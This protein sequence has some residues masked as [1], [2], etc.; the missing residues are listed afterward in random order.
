MADDRTTALFFELFSG[1]PRQGP[2]D[3]DSTLRALALVPGVGPRTRVLDVGCGTGLHTRVLAQALGLAGRLEARVGDMRQLDFPPGS[4][5]L[6]W[7]EGAIYV[8]GFEAGLREWRTLLAP[9]GHVAVTEVCWMRPDPPPEC[10]AFWAQEYPAIRDVADRL[11]T[12]EACGYETVGHFT[13]PPSSWWNDYYL[14][15]EA[16]LSAFREIHHGEADAQGLADQ[17]AREIDVWRRYSD[18]YGYEFFVMR[19]R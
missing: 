19:A 13:L 12:I 6:V 2:G 17:V 7:S 3:T 16:N 11:A 10:A 1:L 18:S 9:G 8:M 4:F 15:L 14:P 5:D